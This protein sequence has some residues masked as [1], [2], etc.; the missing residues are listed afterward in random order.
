MDT[1]TRAHPGITI[2]NEGVV[3][4]VWAPFADNVAVTGDFNEW[5]EAGIPLVRDDSDNWSATIQAAIGQE[6][7][8][9]ITHQ[10]QTTL[11]NDP[12]A[13]QIST[14]GDNSIIVSPQFDWEDDNF[15]PLALSQQVIYELHIGT[16]NRSDPATVGTFA[17]A[18]EKLDYLASLGITTIELMPCSESSIDRWWGYTPNFIYAIES[19]YGGR[20][21][22]MDFVKAAHQRNMGVILDVVYNHISPIPTPDIWQFDGWNEN[23][24]GGIYFYNDNRAETPWGATR[25]DYGRPEVRQY[26]ADNVRMW[27]QDCHVDGLR[28]DSTHYIR[29]VQGRN[30]DPSSDIAEGWQVIQQIT[31]TA[32]SIKPSAVL[33]AEDT[34]SNDYI[35]KP[36]HEG[37]AGFDAQWETPF[38]Y[39]LRDM[40][41]N[42][43]DDASRNLDALRS[44]IQKHYN[45]NPFQQVIYSESHDADA[46]GRSRLNEEIAPGNSDNVFAL[47]RSTLAA[48]LVLTLPGIP[49]LFQG[50]EFMEDGSFTHWQQL[51]WAKAETFHGTLQLYKD[52]IA[53]RRNRFGFSAGLLGATLDILHLDNSTKVL[54][55]HRQDKGGPGD[56]VVVAINFTN[57]PRIGYQI[58]FPAQGTWKA[59]FNSDWKGYSEDFTDTPTYDITVDNTVGV[60]NLAP[61]ST[62]IFSQD[63]VR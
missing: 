3:F 43:I 25:P 4:C 9:V 16:F 30:N 58:P 10:G 53:L 2:T 11:K 8:Y 12:R 42:P 44:A 63:P 49:M 34:A 18:I 29:N 20:H 57:E 59:R 32:R 51:D 36:T 13:L 37:G 28:V 40:L 1:Q 6:Y 47:R 45:N 17:A 26:I 22:F 39:V 7:K 21:A 41:L 52:L 31:D 23:S 54:A 15:T 38:P 55:L 19:A 27:V 46:N 35:T 24:K 62:V 60:V 14:S 61:Y 50:Q 5:N 48:A 56:D 33:I